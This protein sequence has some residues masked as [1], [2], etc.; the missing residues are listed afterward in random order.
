MVQLCSMGRPEGF[1]RDCQ[2]VER[3]GVSEIRAIS[4]RLGGIQC[5]PDNTVLSLGDQE[6]VLGIGQVY[7][8]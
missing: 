1:G 8:Q 5:G 7:F 2:I 4:L 6:F 3:V